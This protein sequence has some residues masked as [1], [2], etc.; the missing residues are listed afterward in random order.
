MRKIIP[1]LMMLVAIAGCGGDKTKPTTKRATVVRKSSETMPDWVVNQFK[2]EDSTSL[3]FVGIAEKVQGLKNSR[4]D[5]VNDSIIQLAEYLGMQVSTKIKST[6]EWSQT[7]EVDSYLENIKETMEGHSKTEISIKQ[8][9]TYWEELS[10]GTYNMFILAQTSKKWAKKERVRIEKLAASQRESSQK[11]LAI[12]KD[13]LTDKEIAPA[14]ENAIQAAV[15]SSQSSKNS[16][17]Y[18]EAKTLIIA[19]LS[20]LSF[21]LKNTP[22]YAYFRGGSDTI[23]VI[24]NSSKS[25]A[26]VK[27]LQMRAV[28]VGQLARMTSKVGNTTDK[29]GKVYYEVGNLTAKGREKKP[30]KILV[31]ITFSRDKMKMLLEGD[32][33]FAKQVRELEKSLALTITLEMKSKTQA[34]PTAVVVLSV[35]GGKKGFSKPKLLPQIQETLSTAMAN[36]GYNIISVDIPKTIMTAATEEKAYKEKIIA[37]IKKNYPSAKRLLFGIQVANIL[38]KNEYDKDIIY[39]RTKFSLSLIDVDSNKL[40]K[41]FTV[42][43]KGQGVNVIQAIKRAGQRAQKELGEKLKTF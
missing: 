27:G 4:K 18:E 38:G 40:E 41:G 13:A 25:S 8:I 30:K 11:Y 32:E 1:I 34:T 26:G 14:Y 6:K 23:E 19:I 37:H 33:D 15:V 16:D 22:K 36:R 31:A 9:G 5:A 12:A 10:D 28:G 7:N 42:S 24:V 29:K 21:E 20:S 17:I 43:S 2:H 3:Y 39:V 35:L